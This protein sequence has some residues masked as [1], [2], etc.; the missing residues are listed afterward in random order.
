MAVAMLSPAFLSEHTA[1]TVR[2]TAASAW[3]GTMIS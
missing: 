3:N 2:P 1:R